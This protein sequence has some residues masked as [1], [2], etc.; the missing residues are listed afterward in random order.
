MKKFDY[1]IHPETG[2]HR[3]PLW[4]IAGY[5]LNDAA[6]ILYLLMMSY[7]SYYLIGFVG[8]ATMLASNL[9][10]IMRVWD[11]V[12]DPLIGFIVDKTNGRF[13]K[14]RPFMIIGNLILCATSFIMYFVTPSLPGWM[15]L[16]FFILISLLYYIGYTCQCIVTKSAL[17][18]VTN[19]PKQRPRYGMFL[20]VFNNAFGLGTLIYISNVLVP[21]YGSMYEL[22]L[23]HDIWVFVAITSGVL[24][25]IAVF[26]IAPKDKPEYYG[27]GKP[28]KLKLKDYWDVLKHNRALQLLVLSASTDKLG[29]STK[30]SAVSV[31]MYGILVGNYTLSGGFNLYVIVAGALFA[32]VGMGIFA[33]R[34]G[35]KKAMQVGSWGG[36]IFNVF[37]VLL[38]LL[39][40]PKTLNLPGYVNGYGQAFNGISFFT[41]ALLTLTIG[42]TLFQTLASNTVYPMTADCAD[43]ETY[44]SGHYVPGMIGTIFSFVDKMV[45]SFAPVLGGLLF[46]MIGFSEVLPDIS[47]PETAALKFVG[48]FLSY[49]MI[50]VGYICNLIAMKFYPLTKEKM[51]EIQGEIIQI[52]HTY[53]EKCAQLENA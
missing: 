28:Q 22:G 3:S 1:S 37:L 21:K 49:G 52:K 5:S 18:C 17:P 51:A 38:W 42:G 39:G 20:S 29:A 34:V 41:G 12:T 36:I 11:G 32:V 25:L 24:T 9:M 53:A 19:D 4:R 26:S 2:I 48:I 15:K 14:N 33:P 50:V 7:T 13:G 10:A 35:L 31:V 43:Y 6:T 40:D 44:R 27:T 46:A 30:T 23:F 45:S 16:P 8:V 47:T